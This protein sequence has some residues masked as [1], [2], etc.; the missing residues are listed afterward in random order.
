MCCSAIFGRSYFGRK[1]VLLQ[2]HNEE[3]SFGFV[4]N[5]F[6]DNTDEV[7]DDLP[8]M[9]TESGVGAPVKRKSIL[10]PH[11]GGHF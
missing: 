11:T 3:G 5:N 7:M 9:N 1:V 6:V 4:L 10:P 8:K 2:E